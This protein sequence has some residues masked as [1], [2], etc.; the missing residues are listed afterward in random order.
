MFI[1]FIQK[2]G[3]LTYEGDKD[4]LPA[5]W[6]AYCKEQ[7]ERSNFYRDRLSHL[8]FSGLN[9]NSGI[10]IIDIN[11]GGFLKDLI[12]TVPFLNGGLFEQDEE[13]KDSEILVPDE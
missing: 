10:N 8:F 13:E 4:Y 6:K 12:G 3:W 7:N 2:K 9:N 11:N 1:V 5:L